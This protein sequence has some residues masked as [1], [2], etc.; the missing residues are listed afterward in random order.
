MFGQ[1]FFLYEFYAVFCV[2]FWWKMEIFRFCWFLIIIYKNA[3]RVIWLSKIMFRSRSWFLSFDT[4]LREFLGGTEN[5]TKV[6]LEQKIDALFREL[7]SASV[8]YSVAQCSKNY[9]FSLIANPYKRPKIDTQNCETKK[10]SNMENYVD[11]RTVC[12]DITKPRHNWS[13]FCRNSHP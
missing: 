8:L 1:Y 2:F 3:P 6:G 5:I 4:I 9:N 13:E 7:T 12:A 11:F 10:K